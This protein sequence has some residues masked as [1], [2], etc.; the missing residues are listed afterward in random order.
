LIQLEQP[1][2]ALQRGQR[3]ALT[4]FARDERC[5]PLLRS[6]KR[7]ILTSNLPGMANVG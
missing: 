7:A 5:Y 4:P 1:G 3:A 2:S 6:F